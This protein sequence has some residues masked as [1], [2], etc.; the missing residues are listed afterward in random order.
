MN[1][2]KLKQI[3]TKQLGFSPLEMGYHLNISV[4]DYKDIE[5]GEYKLS[6]YEIGLV[7]HLVDLYSLPHIDDEY[8][9][10]VVKKTEPSL[11]EKRNMIS[12]FQYSDACQRTSGKVKRSE[13]MSDRDILIHLENRVSGEVD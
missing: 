8:I 4:S 3:R 10:E 7:E 12:R 13:L 11:L 5:K 2:E 1:N 9:K 6:L